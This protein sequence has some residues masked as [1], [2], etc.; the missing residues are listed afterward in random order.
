M[1]SFYGS[2]YSGPVDVDL[3]AAV[4]TAV[5]WI[6]AFEPTPSELTFLEGAMSARIP[7]RDNL[8]EIETSS[9]LSVEGSTLFMSLPA[10]IKGADGFPHTTPVGFVV[11]ADRLTTIRY[12]HLPSFEHLASRICAQRQLSSGGLGATVTILEIIVDHL[13]DLLERI[14]G[15]LDTMSQEVF[16]RGLK[17]GKHHQ[18]KRANQV[19]SQMLRTVG[20]HGDLISK[21]SESLLS[22]SR[23]IPFLSN[24][25]G[26]MV[27]PD[28]KARLDVVN[29]DGK[30]LHEYQDHLSEKTQFL[31]D[32][33]LGLAN[34]EQNNVFRVLTIVSVIGIPPTFFRV[35]VRHE[36]QEHSGVRLVVRLRLRADAHRRQRPCSSHLVQ[37][38]GMVVA[39]AARLPISA[40]SRRRRAVDEHRPEG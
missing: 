21:V 18:P 22:L 7:T 32:A 10:T 12:A 13:A 30:S 11:N 3:N 31:L 24:K 29:A 35:D 1:L 9:R 2:Q 16:T 38:P 19:L 33:L 23:M 8:L 17:D 28:L 34:I 4:P 14:G 6:D 37:G 5:N 36:F 15:D 26:D 39:P 20:S 25:G 27:T 40:L